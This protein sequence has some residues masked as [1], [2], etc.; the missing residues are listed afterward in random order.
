MKF[1]TLVVTILALLSCAPA[2]RGDETVPAGG[3][4]Y[5]FQAEVNRLMDIIINALYSNKDIFL[6]ELISNASDALDKIRFLGLTDK[7]ILGEGDDAKLVIHISADKEN[8]VLTISDRGIGMSKDDLVQNLG[9]VARSGTSK[10]LEAAATGG[11][12]LSLI[13]QFGVGFY[14]AYLVADRVVVAS[15][16]SN[17][18]QYVWE[19]TAENTFTVYPDPDGNTLGTHGTK[20]MLHLKEDALDY[21]EESNLRKIIERYSEFID[22]PIYLY[23]TK[24][25]KKELPVEDTVEEPSEDGE[26]AVEIDDTPKT[27]TVD[28]TVNEWAL[29]NDHKPVWTRSKDSISNEDYINF[30]KSATKDHTEPMTWTHFK[31]EGGVDFTSLIYI[32]GKA[33]RDLY[34]KYYQKSSSVKLYVRRVLIADEFDEFLPRYLNF[35]KGVVDSDDLPIN[36]SRETLQKNKIL[37]VISKRLVRN[38]LKM[39]E[40][41][42]S[43]GKTTDDA[44]NE[45]VEDKE[46]KISESSTYE[47]FWKSTEEAS[48]WEY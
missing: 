24:V 42:A 8:G 12:A 48:R 9:T 36:V 45:P 34:D 13:G 14:S 6:R 21:L 19:S 38:I 15:K 7:E 5:E 41:L 23:T 22:F 3:E 32:P 31:A 39:L 29:V 25:V 17:E 27:K 18:N 2:V 28:E 46:T 20:I 4:V 30:Y 35:V 43:K 16:R 26:D 40:T 1:L 11:D 33:P 47:K 44:E 37:Q 10:F